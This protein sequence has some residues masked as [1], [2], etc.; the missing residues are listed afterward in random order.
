MLNSLHALLALGCYVHTLNCCMHAPK[1]L[2][3]NCCMHTLNCLRALLALTCCVCAHTDL[4]LVCPELLRACTHVLIAGSL[5]SHA[6]VHA[7]TP[8]PYRSTL[9]TLNLH[10]EAAHTIVLHSTC[11]FLRHPTKITPQRSCCALD[12][13]LK[14]ACT[15]NASLAS[16]PLTNHAVQWCT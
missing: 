13:C 2:A 9:G 10:F 14:A 7:F 15:A 1:K 12:L 11:L 8:S 3:P 6:H 5:N 16:S 4:L